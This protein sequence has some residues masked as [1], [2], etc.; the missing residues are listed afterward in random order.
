MRCKEKSTGDFVIKKRPRS[1]SACPSFL[2][3]MLLRWLAQPQPSCD[4]EGDISDKLQ[5][6]QGAD[7]MR[8]GPGGL[9]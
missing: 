7:A 3:G 2:L 6:T 1:R 8:L 4:H 5:V 9:G